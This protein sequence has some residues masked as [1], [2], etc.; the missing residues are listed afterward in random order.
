MLIRFHFLREAADLIKALRRDGWDLEGEADWAVR[1]T[2]PEAP[3]EAAAR[4]RLHGLGLLTSGALR[5]RFDHSRRA[6]G[7]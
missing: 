5:I 7:G 1:G 2:H 6:P 3:D 4:E